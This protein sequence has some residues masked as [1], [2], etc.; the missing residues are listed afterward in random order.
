MLRDESHE[1]RE[2]M[3]EWLEEEFDSEAFDRDE[4]NQRLVEVWSADA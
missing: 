4:V 2:E 3:L 1:E